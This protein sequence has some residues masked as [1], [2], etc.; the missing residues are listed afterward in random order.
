MEKNTQAGPK[1]KSK[2]RQ[3]IRR[4][5][6]FR[7]PSRKTLRIKRSGEDSSTGE[8]TFCSSSST[9]GSRPCVPSAQGM[10]AMTCLFSYAQVPPW[11]VAT[12]YDP[13][14]AVFF[15]SR[16]WQKVHF[17]C[18]LNV[19]PHN[20]VTDYIIPYWNIEAFGQCPAYIFSLVEEF[21]HF[22]PSWLRETSICNCE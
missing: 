9:S 8:W 15:S 12:I 14:Y 7:V 10:L 13:C 6:N 4:R 20:P 11:K 22:V 21:G 1:W 2:T 16:L 18:L 17:L 19:R 5:W 3:M